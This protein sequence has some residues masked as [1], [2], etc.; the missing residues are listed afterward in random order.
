LKHTGRVNNYYS[1]IYWSKNFDSGMCPGAA[2]GVGGGKVFHKFETHHAELPGTNLDLHW[3][4][5]AEF[6]DRFL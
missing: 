3:D 2:C 1:I 5:N 6:T 4:L